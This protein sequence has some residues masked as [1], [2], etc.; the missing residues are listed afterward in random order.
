MGAVIEQRQPATGA[1]RSSGYDRNDADWYCEPAVAVEALLDAERFIGEVYDPA[2]GGGNIVE[3]CRAR[4][5][6][7]W[8]TDLVDRCGQK[9]GAAGVDFTSPVPTHCRGNVDNVITNPPFRHAE[10][11]IRNA[12]DRAR[13]KVAVLVRLAFLEGQKR[14]VLFESLPMSRVLVFSRRIS[15]P[16]GG[17]GI[18]AKGGAVAFCWIVFSHDH[19]GPPTVGWLA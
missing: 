16:P 3:V 10:P 1:P 4:G 13:Y 15:M 11:F 17:Q 12:L 2:C 14:R 9:Y 19:R 8:G 6:N 5:L 18:E 7:A